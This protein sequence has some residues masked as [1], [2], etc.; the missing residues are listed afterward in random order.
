MLYN[1]LG[2]PRRWHA[3]A[4][5]GTAVHATIKQAHTYFIAHGTPQPLAES[6]H[7][8]TATLQRS[9]LRGEELETLLAQGQAELSTFLPHLETTFTPHQKTELSFAHQQCY[10]GNARLTGTLDAVDIDTKQ[11]TLIIT[12]YKTG[13]PVTAWKGGKNHNA[14]KL[15]AYRRQLLFYTL[16]A[17]SSRDYHSFTVQQAQL[18]FIRQTPE[19]E[20]ATLATQFTEEE[21]ARGKALIQ[22][23]WQ[24]I[25]AA[26][27]TQPE[28]AKATLA[29]VIAFED[30]L[31]ARYPAA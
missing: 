18:R 9:P 10:I 3:A 26:D 25:F 11:K 6:L 2:F 27:F 23:V 12:D 28:H 20:F 1:L 7:F 16:L 24:A 21:L 8:F 19:G 13:K 15:H 4:E 14:L 5:Y 17:G 22:A 31:I 29:S 30:E